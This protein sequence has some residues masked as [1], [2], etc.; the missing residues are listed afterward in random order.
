MEKRFGRKN[1]LATV[2]GRKAHIIL[3][4]GGTGAGGCLGT[5]TSTNGLGARR[6]VSCCWGWGW[7]GMEEESRNTANPALQ[8]P[9]SAARP[10]GQL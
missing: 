5:F 2:G 1:K 7:G 3:D 4:L 8:I 10:V 9:V 6:G